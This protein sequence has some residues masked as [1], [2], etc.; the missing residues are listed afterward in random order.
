VFAELAGHGYSPPVHTSDGWIGRAVVPSGGSVAIADKKFA[1]TTCFVAGVKV[2][3]S[4]RAPALG[5]RKRPAGFPADR[6]PLLSAG[7]G[8]LTSGLRIDPG[9]STVTDFAR[10]RG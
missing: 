6:S 5:S 9:Y 7:S 2:A 4:D 1:V 8:K 10:F 3:I